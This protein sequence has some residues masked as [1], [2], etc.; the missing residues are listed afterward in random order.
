MTGK[1]DSLEKVLA[2]KQMK[3]IDYFSNFVSLT[4]SDPYL[5]ISVLHAGTFTLT[6]SMKLGEF[7][8]SLSQSNPHPVLGAQDMAGAATG[9]ILLAVTHSSLDCIRCLFQKHLQHREE[10]EFSLDKY[11]SRCN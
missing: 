3:N 2:L 8:Q 5:H 6:V 1:H 4:K 10:S 7:A 9:S 11:L